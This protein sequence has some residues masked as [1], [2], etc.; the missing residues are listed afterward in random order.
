MNIILVILDSL[1]KDCIGAYGTPPW[2]KVYTPNLDR[3]AAESMMFTRVYP[4][5]LPT[6]PTRRA[7]YTGKRVYPGANSLYRLKGDFGGG[8]GWGPIPE[9]LDT[10]AEM[11]HD[12]G[13]YRTALISDLYHMFKPSKN[14]WRG[15]DQ[16]TFLR[17]QESDPCRSGPNPKRSDL[18]YWLA[19]ELQTPERLDFLSKC[20]CNMYGREKE[21][22]YFNARVFIEAVRWLEQNRDANKFFL[23]IECF[24]PHEPW[25]VPTYY[26][27]MYDQSEG[28]EHVISLYGDSAQLN[29]QLLRRMHANYSGL[30]TMCDHWFGYF[31]EA[32]KVMGMLET[33]VVF[34]T[35]DHGHSLGENNYIGK[36]GYPSGPEVFDIPLFVRHPQGSGAG[37][38]CNHFLQHHDIPA[39]IL[40]FA[41]VAPTQPLDG[42]SFW[43]PAINQSESIRD[44]VTASFPHGITV[45]DDRWWYNSK[46]DGKSVFLYDLD[47]LHPFTRNVADDHR[48]EVRRLYR[49]ALEDAGGDSFP[50]QLLRFAA[51]HAD[52]PGCS[53]LAAFE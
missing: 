41:N 6:L 15:F 13:G 26:R 45:I 16:W 5:T 19:P 4:E 8:P 29:P 20:L 2:G 40:E 42:K 28:Q 51:D 3:F 35:S 11:L 48:E 39:Q 30:V 23:T 18:D 22:D 9:E 52:A 17:G 46:I 12:R 36:Q 32:L 24:D 43:Q 7:I 34:V 38:Q 37:Q 53:P 33:T 50:E 27:Q 10:I 47:T 31:W 21:E 25:F 14:F 44:H 49:T 1:R